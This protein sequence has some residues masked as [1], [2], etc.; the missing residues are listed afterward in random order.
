MRDCRVDAG[1]EGADLM[2]DEDHNQ[3]WPH[4]FNPS[5]KGQ[6]RETLL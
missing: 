2:T 1:C 3:K 4:E 6:E 5:K